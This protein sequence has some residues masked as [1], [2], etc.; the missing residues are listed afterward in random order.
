L[1]RHPGNLRKYLTILRHQGLAASTPDPI[2]RGAPSWAVTQ[3]GRDFLS[4]ADPREAA[5]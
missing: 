1:E 4:T 2:V 3:A 5:A